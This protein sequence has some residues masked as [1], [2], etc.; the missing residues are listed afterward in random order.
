MGR[1]DRQLKRRC[2]ITLLELL[3]IAAIVA[4]VVLIA[5]P[6][7]R[8]TEREASVSFAKQQL[9]YLAAREQE[10]FLRY[11]TYAPLSKIAADETIGR[12]FDM[13]FSEDE[14]EVNGIKFTG[15][16]SEAMIF[17]IIAELP[18]GAKYRV[19][20]SGEVRAFN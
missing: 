12:D 4:A 15:P 7:L 16:K 5:L 17:D 2:G 14:V 10:Y 13:R 20:Q 9:R 1:P 11:G 8:P 19:D 18:D 3:I 6:T